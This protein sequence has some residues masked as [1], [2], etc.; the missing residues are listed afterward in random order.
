MSKEVKED[1]RFVILAPART[2]STMLRTVLNK[3]PNYKCHGELYAINRILGLLPEVTSVDQPELL[4]LR[5]EKPEEFHKE[6][7]FVFGQQVGLKAIY[8]QLFNQTGLRFLRKLQVEKS[9]KVIHL[10]RN[11]LA[12]RHF[13]EI[14]LNYKAKFRNAEDVVNI[15]HQCDHNVMLN[16]AKRLIDCGNMLKDMLGDD[17][18]LN[19]E[20]E[21]FV[22]SYEERALLFKFLNFSEEDVESFEIPEKRISFENKSVNIDFVDQKIETD[23]FQANIANLP[24]MEF[25]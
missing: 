19:I 9:I 10:W 18:F 23:K 12:A 4:K 7:K 20:Y 13:S 15:K 24:K 25:K 22:S 5:N 2:G 11:D 8:F 16:E 21:K 17:R 6:I 14:A 1:K 3:L